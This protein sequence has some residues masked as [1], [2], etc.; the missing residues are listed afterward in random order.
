MTEAAPAAAAPQRPARPL[1]TL[2]HLLLLVAGWAGFVWMWLLV[3]T[4]PWESDRLLWLILG[5]LVLV[6]LATG[7][8]VVHNRSLYRRKGERRAVPV[9]DKPYRRDWRGRPVLADWAAMAVSPVVTIVVDEDGRKR[10]RGVESS[11]ARRGGPPG[12]ASAPAAP[13]VGRS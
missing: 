13:T 2:L 6:P 8:W 1:R 3:A 4:R 12:A 10:Y 7:L 5:A 9:V 11:R